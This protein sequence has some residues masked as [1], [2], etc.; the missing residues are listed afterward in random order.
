MESIIAQELEYVNSKSLC[1][2]DGAKEKQK[3]DIV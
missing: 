2:P 3:A 1:V